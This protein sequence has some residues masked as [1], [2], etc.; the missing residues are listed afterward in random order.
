MK[1]DLETGP[2]T[3]NII[4]VDGIKITLDL[5]RSLANPDP[6]LLYRMKRDGDTTVVT[7]AA[8]EV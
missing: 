7:L 1:I 2:G 5:L 3:L 4:T 8:V 6:T